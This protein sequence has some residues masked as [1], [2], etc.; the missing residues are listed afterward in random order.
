[1]DPRSHVLHLTSL[2][3]LA[4]A[5]CVADPR[6]P[7]VGRSHDETVREVHFETGELEELDPHPGDA[8]GA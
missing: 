3:A 1:M 6:L 4:L 7:E 5:G 2:L 8:L